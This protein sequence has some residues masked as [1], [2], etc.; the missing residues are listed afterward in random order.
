M[1]GLKKWVGFGSALVVA[2]GLLATNHTTASAEALDMRV[3]LPTRP[4]MVEILAVS[5]DGILASYDDVLRLSTDG[6]ATWLTASL[7]APCGTENGCN[8]LEVGTPQG[9]VVPLWNVQYDDNE[10]PAIVTAFTL[11]LSTNT[12]GNELSM[13]YA[14]NYVLEGRGSRLLLQGSYDAAT[15]TWSKQVLDLRT[16]DRGPTLPADFDARGLSADG[17]VGLLAVGESDGIPTYNLA[18]AD[19]AGSTTVLDDTVIIGTYTLQAVGALV[20][21]APTDVSYQTKTCVHDLSLDSS[22]CSATQVWNTSRDYFNHFTGAGVLVTAEATIHSDL[23]SGEWYPVTD[24]SFGPAV[25]IEVGDWRPSQNQE[26]GVPILSTFDLTGS[27]LVQPDSSGALERVASMPWARSPVSPGSLA[28]TPASVVGSDMRDW[29]LVDW[30]DDSSEH[31]TVWRR[32]T[33]G[34]SLGTEEVFRTVRGYPMASGVR[35]VEPLAGGSDETPGAVVVHDGDH[36]TNLNFQYFKGIALSGPYLLANWSNEDFGGEEMF[37]GVLMPS[38]DWRAEST[39]IGLFGSLILERQDDGSYQVADL[40][41]GADPVAF[42][43]DDGETAS[44]LIWGDWIGL[45]GSA[46]VYDYRTGRTLTQSGRIEALGDGAAIIRG[47]GDGDGCE[48]R[49]WNLTTNTVGPALDSQGCGAVALDGNRVA[50][51]TS[52][53]L[54]VTR[55]EGIVTSAPRSLGVVASDAFDLTDKAWT[56]DVDLTKPV[57]AGQLEVSDSAGTVVRRIDVPASGTGSL[58]G[59]AWDGR[60]DAGVYV[61]SG[62]YTFTL[63][64]QASDGSGAVVAVDGTDRPLGE[65]V[66]QGGLTYSV[67]T[68]SGDAEVGATLTAD[69]GEWGPAPVTLSFQWLRDGEPITGADGATYVV[70]GEDAGATLTVAVTGTKDGYAST[71][72]SSTQ[73]VL[74]PGGDLAL[75]APTPGISGTAQVGSMVTAEPGEWGPAPVAL[76]YQWFRGT[77]PIEGATMA[78]Y[79]VKPADLGAQ[80]T[81]QVTGSKEGYVPVTMTSDPTAKVIAGKLTST[82]V[83]AISDTTPMGGQKLTLNT[84]VW[85]PAPVDLAYQWFRGSSAIAGATGAAYTVQAGDVGSTLAVRVTGSKNGYTSVSKTSPATG[86]VKVATIS[87]TPTPTISDTTPVTDQVLS[88]VPGAWGPD[89]VTL[90]YRWYRKSPSGTVKAI[91]GATGGTYQAKA[92]DVGYRLQ[93][94]VTGSLAGA[95]SASKSSAWTA[96]VAKAPF[97]TATAPTVSGVV[98][99]G[100]PV[101]VV[102]G[103]WDPSASFK[104]QW[105]RVS[106][107]GKSTAIRGATRATYK[108]TSTDK[109]K[110]LKVRVKGYRAGYVTTTRYSGLTGVVQPPMVGATPKITGTRAVDQALT[111]SEGTWA[112]AAPATALSYQWYAKSPSGKVSKISGATSRTYQVNGRYAGYKLKVAVVGTASGYASVT[113]TSAYTTTIAKAKFTTAVPAITGTAQSGQTLT[114]VKGDWQP[115]P[116]AFS[117]Q[118]YRSG[119]PITGAKGSTY[120]LVGKD[121][122]KKITVK[123]TAKRVGY[124]TASKTS[125]PTAAVIA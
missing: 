98:R 59:I 120:A 101:T 55:V 53:E 93:V 38:G 99:V 102:T 12:W 92:S 29:I 46:A 107:T 7:P 91:S 68:I 65:V 87:P 72:V 23:V 76:A 121:V 63:S 96:K 103:S 114:V 74:V 1:R 106:G 82:P 15:Q 34:G 104:Y 10:E 45:S 32:A 50:Y 54:V 67:P 119:T 18:A 79:A 19:E 3:D 30:E 27:Y 64:S 57:D 117:Y 116:S 6:G 109:G 97:V 70:T 9:A 2:V 123:V 71:T 113:K 124:V 115:T 56:L 81:V 22:T 83:P 49:V 105:Y 112:P 51:S 17:T 25:S 61:P 16:G 43:L 86:V 75:T 69:P 40:T 24:G 94:K 14:G 13:P 125:A 122:G 21:Y 89:G 118:W 85:G 77:G 4:G 41:G 48:T 52:T 47:Y 42:S 36:T 78:Q 110:A 73:N 11:D 84:G 28:L 111:V 8:Q 33:V 95:K 31:Q 60:N 100:M 58:R 80:L 35:L 26:S 37:P 90:K 108:P 5:G 88:A 39:A 20:Y 62:T 66:V 44:G